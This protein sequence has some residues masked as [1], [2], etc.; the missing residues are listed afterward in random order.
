MTCRAYNLGKPCQRPHV[1]GVPYCQAHLPAVVSPPQQAEAE[2]PPSPRLGRGGGGAEAN[3]TQRISDAYASD[4]VA[5]ASDSVR[6]ASPKN[7]WRTCEG[8]TRSGE[9][10]GFPPRHGEDFCINHTD[11][12]NRQEAARN[13]GR[14]SALARIK[15]SPSLNLLSTVI[16]LT[17]RASIQAASDVAIRLYIGERIERDKFDSLIRACSVAMRNFDKPG[18]TLAGPKPQTHEWNGYF[19]KVKALLKTVD[20]LLLAAYS[21]SEARTPVSADDVTPTITDAR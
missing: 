10:C 9:S 16:S 1:P 11:G 8:T 20:P 3:A 5:N 14:A 2:G 15:S 12:V 4:S 6:Q 18:D 21:I 7:S 13:A 19:L 17:D